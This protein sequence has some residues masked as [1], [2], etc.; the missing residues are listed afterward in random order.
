MSGKEESRAKRTMQR[1]EWTSLGPG[2][3]SWFE[4]VIAFGAHT[5][6][7]EMARLGPP[8]QPRI[9]VGKRWSLYIHGMSVV[10]THKYQAYLREIVGSGSDH[11]IMRKSQ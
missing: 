1:G 11:A 9:S 4:R 5:Q 8:G 7:P 6:P 2:P 3:R 10:Q